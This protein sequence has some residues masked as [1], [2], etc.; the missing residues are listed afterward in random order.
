MIICHNLKVILRS[1]SLT[2]IFFNLRDGTEFEGMD[3]KNKVPFFE[4]IPCKGGA[5]DN[6]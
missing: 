6:T 5:D 3:M 1:Y 4:N 2:R